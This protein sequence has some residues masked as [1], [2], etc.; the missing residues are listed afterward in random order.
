METDAQAHAH[1]HTL[2]RTD[3]HIFVWLSIWG[4]PASDSGSRAAREC[5]GGRSAD[6][7]RIRGQMKPGPDCDFAIQRLCIQGSQEPVAS[8]TCHSNMLKI[9]DN[10]EMN[11]SRLPRTP[12]PRPFCPCVFVLTWG[13]ASGTGPGVQKPTARSLAHS[14]RAPQLCRVPGC[15]LPAARPLARF[16]FYACRPPSSL[17]RYNTWEPEENILDP[18]LLIAFQNR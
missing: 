10:C 3:G 18:R 16:F 12:P 6:G 2:T 1:T 5:G 17:A 14:P 7:D 13:G 9:L 8:G 11:C 15:P 4:V